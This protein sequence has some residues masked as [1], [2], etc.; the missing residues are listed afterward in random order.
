MHVP[1]SISGAVSPQ[2]SPNSEAVTA[3]IR[4]DGIPIPLAEGSSLVEQ[5]GPMA[6]LASTPLE[7]SPFVPIWTHV[8]S[9]TSS[10]SLQ[11]GTASTGQPCWLPSD[12]RHTLPRSLGTSLARAVISDDS[13]DFTTA[14]EGDQP[15]SAGRRSLAHTY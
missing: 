11:I 8:Q 9:L 2:T 6:F 5:H 15:V 7:T 12:H 3:A 14:V 13:G 4:Y 1:V 10:M